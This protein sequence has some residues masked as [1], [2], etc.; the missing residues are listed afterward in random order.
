MGDGA[1][2]HREAAPGEGGTG[3]AV[4][5]GWTVRAELPTEGLSGSGALGDTWHWGRGY[6]CRRQARETRGS[7]LRS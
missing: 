5:A 4:P 6:T 3:Q 7:T 2:F 1:Q